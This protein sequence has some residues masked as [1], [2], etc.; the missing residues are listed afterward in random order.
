[1]T[2]TFIPTVAA[3][4]IF[5][6]TKIAAAFNH[7]NAASTFT[8]FCAFV[9]FSLITPIVGSTTYSTVTCFNGGHDFLLSTVGTAQRRVSTQGWMQES[10][11]IW[12]VLKM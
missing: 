4:R 2:D 3:D 8:A 12:A 1:M 5:A 6:L 9:F 7:I 10:P 11:M